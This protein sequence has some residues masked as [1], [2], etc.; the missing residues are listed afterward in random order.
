MKPF[1]NRSEAGK[2]LAGKRFS[3]AAKRPIIIDMPLGGL[4]VAAEIATRLKAPLN[5]LAVKKIGAPA[6]P[7]LAMDAVTEDGVSIFNESLVSKHDSESLH[8]KKAAHEKAPK[9][10]A[11]VAAC[12]KVMPMVSI[13][14]RSDILVDDGLATGASMA[15]TTTT[16]RVL[17]SRGG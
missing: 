16:W 17:T 12:R 8:V 10:K 4:P 15:T 3:Y 11:Q 6:P 5:I 2:I 9:V 1:Q 13:E 7:G 14:G